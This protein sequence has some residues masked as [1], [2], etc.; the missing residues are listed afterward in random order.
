MP[1]AALECYPARLG[2]LVDAGAP[3]VAAE[4]APPNA[5]ERHVRLV[6]D[7]AVVD[8]RH[9]G[10]EAPRD[11]ETTLLVARHDAGREAVLGVVRDGDG[12]VDA[13][14]RD[15][16]CDRPERLLAHDFHL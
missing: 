6:V 12:L 11:R 5:A 9:A 14:D 8:V 13:A 3:A 1:A 15:H 2:E 16:G 7:R 10:V 4:A